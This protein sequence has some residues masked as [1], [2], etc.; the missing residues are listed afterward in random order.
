MEENITISN[1]PKLQFM[2]ERYGNLPIATIGMNRITNTT[3]YINSIKMD[4]IITDD[5]I[6][7]HLLLMIK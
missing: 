3:N 6:D 1:F 5:H 2:K 4:A 7:D